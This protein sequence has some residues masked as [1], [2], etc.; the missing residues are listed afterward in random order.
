MNDV[1]IA[2]IV[3]HP[4]DL[5]AHLAAVDDPRLGAVTTFVGACATTTRMPTPR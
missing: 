5:D 3:E 2:A 1:R 4:L